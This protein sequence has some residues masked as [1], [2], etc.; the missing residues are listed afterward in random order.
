MSKR[1]KNVLEMHPNPKQARLGNP[2]DLAVGLGTRR[3]AHAA[4]AIE[5][6]NLQLSAFSRLADESPWSHRKKTA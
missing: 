4:T 1:A 6:R 5:S 3:T 2:F